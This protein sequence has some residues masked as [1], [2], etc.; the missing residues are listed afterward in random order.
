MLNRIE[1]L[2][3]EIYSFHGC[4]PE[5]R[6]KG[7]PF[8]V[9]VEVDFDF[10]ESIKQDNLKLTLD[11]AQITDIIKKEMSQPSKLIESVTKRILDNIIFLGEEK[12]IEIERLLVRV[13]KIKPPLEIKSSGI[14]SVIIYKNI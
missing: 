13:S 10:T 8:T 6:K 3:L 2:K 4:N 7:G 11:Y 14:S 1:I 9:D 5:E 12:G